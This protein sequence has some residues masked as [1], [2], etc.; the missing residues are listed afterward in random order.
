MQI[1]IGLQDPKEFS[2]MPR[3]KLVQSGI[4]RY[5]SEQQTGTVK[6][7]LPITPA[8]LHRIRDYWLPRSADPDIKML[9]AAMTICFFGFF[10]SGEITVPSINS[11][12]PSV[13]LAWGDVSL[14]NALAPTMLR[15]HLKKSKTDQ[16]KKGADI[17]IG[18]SDCLLCP[19]GAGVDYMSSR[20]ANPGPFFKFANGQPLTKSKF[21]QYVRE[22]LQALGLP[23][24]EFAGHSF[25]IGAATAA[26]QAGIKD[27]VIR[28]M[29]RWNSSA[30][31]VYIRTPPTEL[32][33]FTRLLTTHRSTGRN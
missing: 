22:A 2:S 15:V 13:H 18:K 32:A 30:F 24:N 26:A 5:T 4:Q 7:R 17:F 20:G 9:W 10:R 11:F 25:R 14:D 6:I 12:N 8:I 31:L 23:H 19:V 1:T 16:L 28:T 27:S 33:Q 21:T 3:L 29:G